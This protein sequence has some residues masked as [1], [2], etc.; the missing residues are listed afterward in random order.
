MNADISQPFV[1]SV[2]IKNAAGVVQEQML[3]YEWHPWFCHKGQEIGHNCNRNPPPA[4]P[5]QMEQARPIRNNRRR[6]PVVRDQWVVVGTRPA[7][8]TQQ[9]FGHPATSDALP[10]PDIAAPNRSVPAVTTTTRPTGN[11][12]YDITNINSTRGLISAIKEWDNYK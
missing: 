8:V 9:R 1:K 12:F 2:R 4:P 3:E 6:N 7:P 10:R 5:R 11:Q